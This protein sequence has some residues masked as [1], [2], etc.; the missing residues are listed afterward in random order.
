[1]RINENTNG[2][3]ASQNDNLIDQSHQN[4][5]ANSKKGFFRRN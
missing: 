5:N 1:M 4:V 3:D 2:G